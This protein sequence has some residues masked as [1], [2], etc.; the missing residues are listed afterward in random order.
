MEFAE[1][2]FAKVIPVVEAPSSDDSDWFLDFDFINLPP[3]NCDVACLPLLDDLPL[4]EE[5]GSC[6]I[7]HQV[8]VDQESWECE[9]QLASNSSNSSGPASLPLADVP[10][11]SPQSIGDETEANICSALRGP[12]IADFEDA[13]S[14]D[15]ASQK[16]QMRLLRNRELAFESRQRRK[17]YINDLES[18][19]KMLEKERNQ[20][21]QQ[22][23]Q[24]CTENAV[25]KEE[26]F[27]LKKM[28]GSTGV[29]EPAV[30]VKG[31][32]PLE[33]LSHLTC[34]SLLAWLLLF[35]GLFLA[36]L[37]VPLIRTFSP[38]RG[39]LA[40]GEVDSKGCSLPSRI[41]GTLKMRSDRHVYASLKKLCSF[42]YWKRR[43]RFTTS[44]GHEPMYLLIM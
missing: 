37:V 38:R 25:L 24:F 4:W 13:K 11:T 5:K 34:L 15:S 29:A 32:L 43:S 14:Q 42:S 6:S 40:R 35:V 23:F 30:L 8:T 36:L 26:I 20:L 10:Q 2:N 12:Q 16:K 1:P 21:H 18:K 19:C 28:K 33:F 41:G 3:I 27:R 7:E 17:S 9:S 44:V 22:Y 31:S 39:G